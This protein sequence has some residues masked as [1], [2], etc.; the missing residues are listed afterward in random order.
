MRTIDGLVTALFTP[1]STGGTIDCNSLQKLVEYQVAHGAGVLSAGTTGE[2]PT[3]HDEQETIDRRVVS[4][5]KGR[6]PVVIGAGTNDTMHSIELTERAVDNGADATLHVMGYYNKPSQR[7]VMDYFDEVA[8]IDEDV[9]VI[10]YHIPGRG[11]AEYMAEVMVYLANQ[12]EN[13]N[14]LKEAGLTPLE[15]AKR[16]RELTNKYHGDF[17]ISDFSIMSGD[18]DKTFAMMTGEADGDGVISVM[19]NLLPNMYRELVRLCTTNSYD[20][21][22]L[23]DVL[24]PLNS[25][26]GMKVPDYV[27]IEGERY[28]FTDTYRNPQPV[29]TAAY[30]L[31]M[32]PELGFRAP[33]VRMPTTAERDVGRALWRVYEATDGRAFEPL[34]A[35][36]KPSPNVADRL[37]A[38][39][40]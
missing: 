22:K 13:I 16:V 15:T 12:H 29:K 25:I 19:A 31:G 17:S 23:N 14:G 8:R 10:M 5:A 11:A 26:V 33:M 30:I 39:R 6:V 21:G 34:Q 9:P 38:Y 18:D 37:I 7:G 32:T 2:S 20:A 36:F 24:S 28:D 3:L 27:S 4:I 1:M 40:E 35:F